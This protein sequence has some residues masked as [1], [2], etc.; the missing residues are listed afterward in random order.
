MDDPFYLFHFFYFISGS[1]YL[2]HTVSL[3]LYLSY[4]HLLWLSKSLS[5]YLQSLSISLSTNDLFSKLKSFNFFASISIVN[6][7]YYC[8]LNK[9]WFRQL[10]GHYLK[11]QCRHFSRSYTCQLLNVLLISRWNNKGNL[12]LVNKIKIKYIQSIKKY[13][14]DDDLFSNDIG[15]QICQKWF[16]KQARVHPTVC[17]TD[18]DQGREILS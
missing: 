13:A 4:S 3:F 16:Q 15:R 9:Y 10:I 8:W 7:S 6:D 12:A 2:S 5:L 14:K 11:L 17:F 1:L 18:L